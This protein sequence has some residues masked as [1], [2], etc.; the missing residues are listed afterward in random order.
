MLEVLSCVVRNPFRVL[1]VLRRKLE[2]CAFLPVIL[3]PSLA[4]RGCLRIH[5]FQI[6][7]WELR[8]ESNGGNQEFRVLTSYGQGRGC[9]QKSSRLHSC[10][11]NSH[12]CDPTE[13]NDKVFQISQSVVSWRWGYRFI[14]W[15]AQLSAPQILSTKSMWGQVLR[16]KDSP[17]LKTSPMA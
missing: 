16:H 17:G 6:L 10:S 11:E 7:C 3:S 4:M 5:I 12:I 14:F 2:A 15:E 13:L 8:E 1:W 9:L